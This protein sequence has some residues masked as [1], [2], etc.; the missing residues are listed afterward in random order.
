VQEEFERYRALLGVEAGASPDEIRRAYRTAVKAYHPDVAGPDNEGAARVF[1]QLTQAYGALLEDAERREKVK[2]ESQYRGLSPQELATQT[3]V[4]DR[5]AQEARARWYRRRVA[6]A[7]TTA[8]IASAG[9][10]LG[11]WSGWGAGGAPTPRTPRP[12]LTLPLTEGVALVLL[13]LPA[14]QFRTRTPRRPG[15]R[16]TQVHV[17][18]VPWPFHVAR[19]EITQAQWEAVMGTRPWENRRHARGGADLPVTHVSFHDAEAFCARLAGLCKRTVR[20]PTE[21]EWEYACRAGSNQA[22]CFGTGDE[23]LGEYAWYQDNVFLSDRPQV[24]AV[25][26]RKPNA[27]GLHDMHGNVWEWCHDQA[28]RYGPHCIRGGSWQSPARYCRS[29][30]RGSTDL[31]NPGHDVGFRVVVQK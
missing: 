22:F 10:G 24:R 7:V 12:R 26:R 28:E 5:A 23:R 1:L 30:F 4:D 3:D 15:D 13:E 8:L 6:L 18:E 14:G 25:G 16:D 2:A 27:W 19:T 29:D 9:V 17:A 11:V 21:L 31:E 20:L